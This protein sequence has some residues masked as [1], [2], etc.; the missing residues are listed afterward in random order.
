MF[1]VAKPISAYRA[2]FAKSGCISSNAAISVIGEQPMAAVTSI[3]STTSSPRSPLS[4]FD[5]SDCGLPSLAATSTWLRPASVL[6]CTSSS[7]RRV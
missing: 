4:Y 3:S 6:A 7:F 5:T 2:L 1:G